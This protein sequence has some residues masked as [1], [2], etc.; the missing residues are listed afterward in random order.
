VAQLTCRQFRFDIRVRTGV[1]G[2]VNELTTW[3]MTFCRDIVIEAVVIGK[4][5]NP[6]CSPGQLIYKP[7]IVKQ[8]IF[9]GSISIP[10]MDAFLSRCN[11]TEKLTIQCPILERTP[12]IA[13]PRLQKGDGNGLLG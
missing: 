13:E 5:H 4:F 7:L 8:L 10:Y 6:F 12:Y 11:L 9:M 3:G 1:A 2:Y